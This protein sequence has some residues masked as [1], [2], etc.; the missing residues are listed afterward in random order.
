MKLNPKDIEVSTYRCGHPKCN[1]AIRIKHIPTGITVEY[2]EE[3]S[4]YKN[5]KIALEMLGEKL[6]TLPNN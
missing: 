5:R 3:R 4:Q 2:D 6:N 1:T